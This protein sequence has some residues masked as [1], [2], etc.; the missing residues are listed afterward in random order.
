[1]LLHLFV[2]LFIYLVEVQVRSK[3]V[4][5]GGVDV[6]RY[7]QNCTHV[8]VDKLVYVRFFFLSPFYKKKNVYLNFLGILSF[9]ALAFGST[10]KSIFFF[11]LYCQ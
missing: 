1:M 4:N 9:F 5:G 2:Y 8:V 10:R 6:G 7:G 3:L 11:I